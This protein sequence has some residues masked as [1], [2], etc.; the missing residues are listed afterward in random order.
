MASMPLTCT[1]FLHEAIKLRAGP[2]EFLGGRRLLFPDAG[3]G[4]G[5]RHDLRH[6]IRDGR[7]LCLNVFG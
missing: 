6:V 2:C 4:L 1:Q 5:L 7:Q 3:N